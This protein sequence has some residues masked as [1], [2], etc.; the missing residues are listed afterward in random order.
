M[1][2]ILFGMPGIPCVY[3]GSEWGALGDKS[4]G[5]DALR[6]C[7]DAPQWTDLTDRIAAMIKAHRESEYGSLARH[8]HILREMSPSAVPRGFP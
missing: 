6:P 1:Y 8:R 5:D 2:G 4:Q 3:Y 7:F